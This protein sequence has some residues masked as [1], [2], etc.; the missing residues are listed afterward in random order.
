M[1]TRPD[2]KEALSV[3]LTKE[4]LSKRPGVKLNVVLTLLLIE[5]KIIDLNTW[6][7]AF[8]EY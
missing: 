5:H 4:F 8:S 1:H 2:Q 3:S 6:Q 7:K